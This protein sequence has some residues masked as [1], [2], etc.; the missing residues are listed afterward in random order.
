MERES[1]VLETEHSGLGL[2]HAGSEVSVD[3][4]IYISQ[5]RNH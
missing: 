4:L 5:R 2:G 3:M 1:G